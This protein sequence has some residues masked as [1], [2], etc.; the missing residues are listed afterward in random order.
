MDALINSLPQNE[1]D[2][3]CKLFI[4]YDGNDGNVMTTTQA[5]A[6]KAKGWIPYYYNN[7]DWKEY[8]GSAD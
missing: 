7:D 5:A 1:T 2:N 6:V 4:N 8:E 3:A